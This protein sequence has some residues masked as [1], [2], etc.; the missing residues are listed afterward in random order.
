MVVLAGAGH[1]QYGS[2]IPKRV[3]KRNGLA[4]AIVLN[5]AD[6]DMG[7]ADFIV[8]PE[9]SKSEAAPKL[10]VLIDDRDETVRIKGFVENSV[11]EKAGLKVEDAILALDGHPVNTIEDVK[12]AL[13]YKNA[14]DTIAVKTK[15][16]DSSQRSEELEFNVKLQ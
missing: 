15:R 16:M 1:V 7:I 12:I 3:F 6:V 10:M 14:G 13:F 2:G 8:F 4:Y 9:P 5:D 11:S